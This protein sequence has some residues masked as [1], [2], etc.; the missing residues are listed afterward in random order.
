M[1]ITRENL[2]ELIFV[3]IDILYDKTESIRHG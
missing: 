3:F 2:V 1:Y